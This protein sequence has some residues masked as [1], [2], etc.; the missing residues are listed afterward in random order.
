MKKKTLL[1]ASAAALA[2]GVAIT[3]GQLATKNFV[4]SQGGNINYQDITVAQLEEAMNGD[5]TFTVGSF[6]RWKAEN[7]TFYEE[8]GIKY[9]K[10]DDTSSLYSTSTAGE[11][12]SHRVFPR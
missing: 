7:I 11:E 6:D 8:G 5:G 10:L 9:A 4:K 1:L 12:E 3:V 2:L